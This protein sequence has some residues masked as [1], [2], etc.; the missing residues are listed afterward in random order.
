M[1]TFRRAR[2]ILFI[3]FGSCVAS[4]AIAQPFGASV[5][6]PYKSG[7]DVVAVGYGRGSADTISIQAKVTLYHC[8]PAGARCRMRGD[9]AW[10]EAGRSRSVTN[11]GTGVNAAARALCSGAQGASKTFV[12][13]VEV[14]MIDYI[15]NNPAK[16]FTATSPNRIFTC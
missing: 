6:P 3:F 11:E 7:N 9:G 14:Y 8:L 12:A 4:T 16:R 1:T 5:T 2:A 15:W 13:F 10:Y